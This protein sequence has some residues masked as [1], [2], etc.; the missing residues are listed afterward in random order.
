MSR[1][2]GVDPAFGYPM[3]I[4][5]NI[6]RTTLKPFTLKAPKHDQYMPITWHLWHPIQPARHILCR[7]CGVVHTAKIR[8]NHTERTSIIDI[9]DRP[10]STFT[11]AVVKP[12]AQCAHCHI[13]NF[14]G[15]VADLEYFPFVMHTLPA[16]AGDPPAG[17]SNVQ[18]QQYEL[19]VL[20]PGKLPFV[21]PGVPSAPGGGNAQNA[22][23]RRTTDSQPPNST[24]VRTP[25]PSATAPAFSTQSQRGVP[26]PS[27][28][29]ATLLQRPAQQYDN[30]GHRT[31]GAL[32]STAG[33][34]S[35]QV[36]GS[37]DPEQLDS[38]G[39]PNLPPAASSSTA[40]QPVTPIPPGDPRRRPPLPRRSALEAQRAA[41]QWAGAITRFLAAYRARPEGRGAHAPPSKELVAHYRELGDAMQ[42]IDAERDAL[43]Y[44]T[45]LNTRLYHALAE[46]ATTNRLTSP[47][48]WARNIVRYL[49]ERFPGIGADAQNFRS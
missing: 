47:S 37:T 31:T 14:S 4:P 5:F 26:S 35:S 22:Q 44:Y 3:L 45:V 42:H 23:G 1:I 2:P 49:E 9:Q 27:R 38:F 41:S 6:E 19:S 39:L 11:Q 15:S 36:S 20:P 40:A 34:S 43:V 29:T 7:E 17:T 12:P 48:E 32:S 30:D 13:V 18:G 8:F 28:Q 33:P 10:L 21:A 24:S 16:L 25:G 46:L